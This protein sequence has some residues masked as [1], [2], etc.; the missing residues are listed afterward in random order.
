MMKISKVRLEQIINEELSRISEETLNSQSLED[1]V[2]RILSTLPSEQ[3]A[4][5][6]QYIAL[7][8]GDK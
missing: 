6:R 5:V 7:V 8:R 4:I 3:Q 2:E 1:D